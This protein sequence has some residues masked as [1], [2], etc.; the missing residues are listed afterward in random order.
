MSI[1]LVATRKTN[2][3]LDA[4]LARQFPEDVLRIAGNQWL[5]SAQLNTGRLAEVIDPGGGGKWGEMIVVTAGNYSGRHDLDT[6]EWIDQKRSGVAVAE[7]NTERRT[8]ARPGILGARLW[9]P[10]VRW[11]PTMAL[12]C[13]RSW[14]FGKPRGNEDRSR[15]AGQTSRA[16]ATHDTL[17]G[18]RTLDGGG[19]V[20]GS[21][22][23]SGLVDQ[24]SIRRNIECARAR[25][26]IAFDEFRSALV[27]CSRH[28]L[29]L[30]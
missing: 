21:W 3:K 16:A 9:R 13:K 11:A 28:L 24:S 2:D 19:C 1:Y 4:A 27:R 22:T 7:S 14:S 6:W 26:R 18:V 29:P 23:D 10:R 20:A 5:V 15:N 12:R 17:D 30:H 25:W 8:R